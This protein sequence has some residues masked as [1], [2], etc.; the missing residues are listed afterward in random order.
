MSNLKTHKN[1]GT[2]QNAQTGKRYTK[3]DERKDERL[4][5]K[6]NV[7]CAYLYRIYTPLMT[8][9]NVESINT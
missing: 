6:I 8:D 1:F 2:Q 9:K 3:E 5:D 4:S 7:F